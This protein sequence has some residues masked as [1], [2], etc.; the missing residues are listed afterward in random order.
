MGRGLARANP[1]LPALPCGWPDG[2]GG[3][4]QGSP[5]PPLTPEPQSLY[6]MPLKLPLP[7]PKKPFWSQ[8]QHQPLGGQAS[9]CPHP[10]NGSLSH[11]FGHKTPFLY[12]IQIANHYLPFLKLT[13][14][15]LN[16]DIGLKK[17][18]YLSDF[19]QAPFSVWATISSSVKWHRCCAPCLA[20]LLGL[21]AMVALRRTAQGLWVS[22]RLER[23]S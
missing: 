3:R 16:W 20:L 7:N 21:D 9:P 10:P 11:P 23:P 4:L 8:Q 13:L 6:Q 2:G 14:W 19:K 18:C 5:G 15:G 22:A 1:H 17:P 12:C